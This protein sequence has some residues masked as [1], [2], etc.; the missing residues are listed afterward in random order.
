VALRAG[1]H[2]I[3]GAWLVQHGRGT[4]ALKI[5]SS[6]VRTAKLLIAEHGE[7]ASQQASQRANELLDERDIDGAIVWGQI[8]EAI[9]ELTRN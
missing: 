6:I 5:Y 2:S 8:H 4:K 3:V 9:E 7:G 1:Q